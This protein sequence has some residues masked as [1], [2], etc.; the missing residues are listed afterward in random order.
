MFDLLV[1]S[2]EG[3]VSTLRS[4]FEVVKLKAPQ[5]RGAGGVDIKW[6]EVTDMLLFWY[7][8]FIYRFITLNL[9]R[10]CIDYSTGQM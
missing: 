1:N 5:L 4:Y 10:V 7:F 8:W 2:E 6:Y 3:R 9:V